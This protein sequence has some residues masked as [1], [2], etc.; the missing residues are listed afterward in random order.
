MRLPG[1]YSL[2]LARTP[3][4]MVPAASPRG[5]TWIPVVHEPF[6]GA[7]QRNVEISDETALSYAPV[8]ACVDLISSDCAKLRWR[9]VEQTSDGIWLE[10]DN[11]AY[12]PLLRRPNRYQ[13]PFQFLQQWHVSK[14]VHGNTY[15]LKHRDERGV[16]KALYLLDPTA[17][18]PLVAGDG[19]VWYQVTRAELAG[20]DAVLPPAIPAREIMHDR[21]MAPFHPLCGVSPIFGASL[22]ASHGVT[23]SRNSEVFFRNGSKPG[24]VLLA[25]GRVSDDTVKRLKEYWEANFTGTNIGKVAVLGDNLKYEPLSYNAVD[26]QLIDQLKWTAEM[27]CAVYHVPAYMAQIGPPPPYANVDPLIQLYYSQSLQRLL[28]SAEQVIDHGLEFPRPTLGTEFDIDDLIWMNAE[29]RGKAAGDAIVSGMAP[30]EVRK[31]FYNLPP[32]RGGATPYLQQQMYSLAAL[33]ARDA[34]DPFAKPAP[35]A[36]PAE[37]LDDAAISEEAAADLRAWWRASV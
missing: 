24:G 25:P 28:V 21:M 22:A 30:N 10:V 31:K 26:A 4:A 9:L 6:T 15:A 13:V 17:V 8:F 33:A 7:W 20:L 2:T 11:P 18:T 3:R 37:E 34:A 29:T 16:V 12:S 27:I 36:P 35:P 1:G 14:L 32:V 23:I 5:D 19:S